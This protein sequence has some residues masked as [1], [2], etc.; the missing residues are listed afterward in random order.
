MKAEEKKMECI[1]SECI[2]LQC[3]CVQR[4]CCTYDVLWCEERF[5][6]TRTWSACGEREEW[7]ARCVALSIVTRTRATP[8]LYRFA[9]FAGFCQGCRRKE[10]KPR[11]KA[12]ALVTLERAPERERGIINA[13]VLL[14]AHKK[15][16]AAETR[17]KVF[18]LSLLTRKEPGRVF[19]YLREAEEER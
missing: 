18:L 16:R 5:N 1:A 6:V 15:L 3:C 14:V 9:G 11:N 2:N 17:G 8:Q 13:R 12:V 10:G 4:E 19:L 7:S